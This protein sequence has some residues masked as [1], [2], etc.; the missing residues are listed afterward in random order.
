M[1]GYFD[2]LLDV[3]TEQPQE[4]VETKVKSAYVFSGIDRREANRGKF[5]S[6]GSI[7]FG[8]GVAGLT[9]QVGD[10]AHYAKHDLAA[11]T[12]IG[13]GD[14][15]ISIVWENPAALTANCYVAGGDFDYFGV[16]PRHSANSNNFGMILPGAVFVSSGTSA[17]AAGIHKATIARRSG[18]IYWNVDGKTSSVANSTSISSISA[19]TINNYKPAGGPSFSMP[20]GTRINLV[21][22]DFA[23]S[24]DQSG[25]S[26]V[27]NPWQI[28]QSPSID[29]WVPSAAAPGGFQAAWAR[30][31]SYVIGAGAR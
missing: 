12:T 15:S 27:D 31:R 19:V 2:E 22:F 29:I 3:W 21:V 9:Y 18:T 25:K 11:A 8:A 24:G 4:P 10:T 17:S 7:D 6:A 13:T 20:V 26:F 23:P 16:T 14:F 1:A 30:N 28:F 5:S